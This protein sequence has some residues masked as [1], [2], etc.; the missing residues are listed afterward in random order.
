MLITPLTGNHDRQRFDCGRVELNDWLQKVARQHR[1]KGLSRT[2]V[3]VLE[4]QPTQICGYYAL[5]L[6]EV[7]TF[8]LP[9]ARRKKLP[10]AI[11]GVRLGRLAVDERYQGRRL[12]ELMLMN[13]LERTRQIHAHAG[14]V[15]LFVDALDEQAAHFYTR[16]GFEAFTDEP[17][18][19][20]LPVH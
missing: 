9:E 13:A 20:F 5:A 18:K 14:V 7:D 3:A 11:P 12:G 2:F 17:L 10:R 19:L 1:D 16:Y 6:T 8:A 4:D 15:G